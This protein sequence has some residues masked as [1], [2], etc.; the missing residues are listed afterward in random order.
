MEQIGS[1]EIT[2]QKRIIRLL[3]KSLKYS[4]LGDWNERENSN[5]EE[6]YLRRY[7][8]GVQQY[9]ATEI[10][11]AITQ[12]KRAAGNIAAGLYH[13]NKE[14]YGL[15]RY[16][17]NISGEASENK[18]Y[19]HLIDWKNP[20]ANDFYVAEEVTVKGRNTK[21]PD[22]VVYINGIALAVIELK[23]STVSVHHGIRQNL[24]NQS[25]EFIPQFY[26]T[27]QLVLAGNDTEGLH[28]G[29]IKTPEK[30]W[31]RWKEPNPAIP[32][33]LDRSIT[34]F[35]DKSRLLDFIHDY[36]IFDGGIKKAARPNQYFA[37]QAAQP[38]IRTKDS[39]IIWHSQGSGKSLTM[40]WL[41]KWI[42]E[43]VDDA[44]VVV[45]TDRDELDEQIET[46]FKG[47][48]E[49][50]TRARS[51]ASLISMLDEANPWLI[52]TLIHKFGNKTDSDLPE[53]G[54]KKANKS[55]EQYLK[56]V[57]EK[58]PLNFRPKGN[59]FVFVDECHR[60]QGGMLHEAM[61][62]IMGESVMLIGFTGTPL[63][64]S[65][66]K[67]SLETFGT[68]IHTYKFDEAV[69]DRVVLDLRYEARDV[70]QYLGNKNKIDEWFENRTGGLSN[71]AKALLKDR[72]ARMEKLF[73]S[74]ERMQRIVADIC[75]DMDTKRA[76]QCGYGNAMLV[77][78]SIYQA[79][80]YW[81]LFQDT[82]LKGHCA[83]VTSY[84]ANA[85]DIKDEATGAG[86]TEEKIKYEITK[87]M[88]GD[89]NPEQFEAWA[90]NEFK[91]HPGSMKLLIVVD[92]LLTGFDAPSATYLYVDKKMRDHNL[93]QAICRVNRVDSEEKDF[94]YI[95]DYQDLF[96]SIRTAIEDYTSEA[97]EGYDK[98]D[99]S[100]LLTNRLTEGRKGFEDA[101][102][103]VVTLCEVVDPQ[104]REG[105]F[106]Y[107]VYREST[108]PEEQSVECE[109]NA[110]K[111]EKLYKLVGTLVRRYIDIA[112]D[113]ANAGYSPS[114]AAELKKQVDFYN[115]LKDEI[116]LKSGDA[117]DLKFYDPAMR[118][119]IDNYVRA[120]DSEGI[121]KLEDISFL[122]LIDL[123]GEGAI[124]KLPSDIKNNQR[125]VAETLVA[126][127]RKMIINERP[128]NPA[129]FDKISELLN[130]LI[131]D[132][133]ADK[134]SY[135]EMIDRMIEKIREVRGKTKKKYPTTINTSGKQ[136]LYD[137]LEKNE[138]LALAVHEAV[139]NYAKHGWRNN[140]V[141]QKMKQVRN[142]VK[143]VLSDNR[144][145]KVREVMGIIIAQKEY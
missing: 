81:E 57:Q 130:Q 54:K 106:A 23:R 109:I 4:N 43:N 108:V 90:K 37:I 61:K 91:D 87:R 33:E 7:L 47:V 15:L 124:D 70:P 30:F 64:K 69:D 49:S 44:R 104:T 55:V 123:E 56:E 88:M 60:T 25:D 129:Y 110:E 128:N 139:V 68:Y 2:T 66:K 46:G 32:N 126:N 112:N 117:L 97:F 125:S 65:D 145:E 94:G 113:M 132:Q 45:I 34:Q 40:I 73:S 121:F 119:L 131:L 107:F 20:L 140:D 127:M 133:Q 75:Q 144:D 59:I 6:A 28:Y 63:L 71:V 51:G 103:A 143:K 10:S 115:D 142:A 42:R 83:V 21:R 53:V 96:G 67:N 27:V 92:K 85:S 8:K 13:A 105:F 9:S 76:L 48:D 72:W 141:P 1:K 122:E 26:T 86:D 18:K 16:G 50:I 102:Q 84:E 29:V 19:V 38:R 11:S 41:A 135:K 82:D 79:C 74:K 78:D 111:R 31:L 95:I 89:K 39:G 101:L 17:V 77:S 93:F 114:E 134:I 118:Q 52:C 138:E 3:D 22:L 120:E 98:E 24:D 100:K 14:V 62:A 136:A 99:I 36:L 137:N 12:L 35:F 80:R 58:L 5:I 116:K